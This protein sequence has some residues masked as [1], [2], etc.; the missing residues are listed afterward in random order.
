MKSACVAA[1]LVAFGGPAAASC[2]T[3]ADLR[4]GVTLVQNEPI[5]IRADVE[6][7]PGGLLE[8]RLTRDAR[9]R[10]TVVT[11]AYEHPLAPLSIRS[12]GQARLR[13]YDP[14]PAALDRLDVEGD[15]TFSVTE[16]TADGSRE[17]GRLL[18]NHTGAGT[19][20]IQ[21]CTYDVWTV[22]L[23]E[24]DASGTIETRDVVYAP[25]LGLVL[26]EAAIGPDGTA[27]PLYDYTWI[28]TAADV[29]R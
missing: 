21:D 28:G 9:E 10:A 16:T 5:F 3:R 27:R 13:S 25:A 4:E 23:M 19:R 11:L 7:Q 8:V 22:R 20:R 1:A 2:P 29:A 6:A 24:A 17:T 15:A 26:A 18:L 12:A 14:T